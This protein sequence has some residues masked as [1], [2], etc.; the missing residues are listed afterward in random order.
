MYFL[1]SCKFYSNS[2]KCFVGDLIKRAGL[3]KIISLIEAHDT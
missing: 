2:K 1:V 3:L